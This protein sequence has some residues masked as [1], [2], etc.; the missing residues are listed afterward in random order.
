MEIPLFVRLKGAEDVL[1]VLP[2][3]GEAVMDDEVV[4]VGETWHGCL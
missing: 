4:A 2:I 3:P 1:A